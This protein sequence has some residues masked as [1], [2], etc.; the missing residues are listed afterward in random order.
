MLGDWG[1]RAQVSFMSK[2]KKKKKKK[3]RGVVRY[4]SCFNDLAL[5]GRLH[6]NHIQP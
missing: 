2:K 6:C 5:I 1:K 4:L 3:G